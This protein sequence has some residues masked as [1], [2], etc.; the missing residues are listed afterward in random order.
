MAEAVEALE[1]IELDQDDGLVA[2]LIERASEKR[3]ASQKIVVDALDGIMPETVSDVIAIYLHHVIAEVKTETLAGY[4][5]FIGPFNEAMGH[6]PL[7]DAKAF[8][9]TAWMAQQPQYKSPWTRRSAIQSINGPFYWAERQGLILKNP[10]HGITAR[11]GIPRDPTEDRWIRVALKNTD[12]VFRRVLMFLRWQGVR[13]SELRNL[14]WD[15]ID[16]AKGFVR[17]KKHKSARTR[18]QYRPRMIYL[19][20]QALRLLS[21]MHA[22]SDSEFVFVNDHGNQWSRD[23]L[24]RR[25]KRIRIRA[26]IPKFVK[27][28][29][30][31]HQFVT[32][33]LKNVGPNAMKELVGHADTRMVD[34]YAHFS[35]QHEYLGEQAA[36]A[37]KGG[38]V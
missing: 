26:G 18:R 25:F 37:A 3:Q 23:A 36:L 8:H 12:A 21:W 34:Y 33:G 1:G 31:R 11:M 16:W 10:F 20:P 15:Q 24:A 32:D 29:G 7:N 28:Y 35:G 6:V 30:I 27:L 9:L 14:V 13:P 5:N 2:V 19:A 22:R 38:A 4:K 17:Q